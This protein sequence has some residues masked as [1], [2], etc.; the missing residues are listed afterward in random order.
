L[1]LATALFLATLPAHATPTPTDCD[2]L[3]ANPID[4]AKLA[5]GRVF[6]D[7]DGPAAEAA[8]KAA[9][10]AAPDDPRFTFQ[11]GRAYDRQD[12]FAEAKAAYLKAFAAGYAIAAQAYGKLAELGLGGDTDY[13]TAAAY[14]QKALD[15][16]FKLAAGDLAYLHQEGLGVAK[17]PGEA[18]K[19]YAVAVAAGDGWSALNLGI[20]YQHGLGVP[21]DAAAAVKHFRIADEAGAAG[22]TTELA[23]A[24]RYGIGVGKDLAAAER[25][26]AKAA[27]SSDRDAAAHASNAYAWMLAQTGGDL[28]KARDLVTAALD[29]FTEGVDHANALDTAAWIDHLAGNNEMALT[30][31]QEAVKIAPETPMFH[32]RLG[33]ILAALG[34]THEAKA[35]WKKAL[36]LPLEGS[37]GEPDW[38][39]AAVEKKLAS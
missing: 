33:D 7:L 19:L 32:D 22:G 28:G 12:K 16:G 6:D 35:E 10:A 15:A 20:L 38:T 30:E 3:A 13:A 5:P 18:A 25:L 29:R 34:R 1:F 26:F 27:A 36:A 8:C 4:P 21:K 24:Y 23:T 31:E 9:L 37:A 14:Y 2:R 17:N 11:L 39:R